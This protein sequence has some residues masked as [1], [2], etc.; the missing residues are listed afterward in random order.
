MT[1]ITI[2]PAF[3]FTNEHGD[4]VDPHLFSLLGAVRDTGKLTLA[5]TRIK[6]SYRHGWDLL[7]RWSTFFGGPLVAMQR[8]K[9]AQ[10]TPLGTTLLW[11]EQ[12]TEA[13]LFPQLENIASELNIEIGRALKT[14][15]SIIRIHAS[16]GYA[17]EKLPGLMRQ[18]GHAT[19][20]L[21]Y[22]GSIAA[23]E[24]LSR[25]RCDLAGFHVPIGKLAKSLWQ[26][27]AK[28]IRPRQQKII[29]LVLRTQGLIV[30]KGSVKKH[31]PFCASPTP[32]RRC[33][34]QKV[35]QR[36]GSPRNDLTCGS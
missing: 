3:T 17:I 16:H 7:H 22:M 1:K 11:A 25:S 34:G 28:W 33:C 31:A 10:L 2:H 36:S 19:V 5:A 35:R 29:R 6:L 14:S 27:Y 32:E 24:S 13:S 8:G 15:Q 21:Q 4:R 26:H 9:G 30:P 20:D 23:L 18:N 12:R